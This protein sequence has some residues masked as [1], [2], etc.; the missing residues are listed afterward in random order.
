MSQMKIFLSTN[1]VDDTIKK[2][3]LSLVSV[4]SAVSVDSLAELWNC[5]DRWASRR[6]NVPLF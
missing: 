2:A 3:D 1:I 5:R 4:L 6:P